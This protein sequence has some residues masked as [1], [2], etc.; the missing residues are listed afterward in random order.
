MALQAFIDDS[1]TSEEFVLGGH[2]AGVEAWGEFSRRWEELLP[3]Y[4][5]KAKNG[6]YHFKMTEMAVSQ[7]RLAR[8]PFFY[9]IIEDCVIC[10][11]SCRMN[12]DDFK[13]AHERAKLIMKMAGATVDLSEWKNPYFIVFRALVQGFYSNRMGFSYRLP[14]DE[15]V[16]FYFDRQNESARIHAT[17]DD[18]MK[19]LDPMA[20]ELFGV[21]PRFEDDQTL[22]PLQGA[23]LWAWWVRHWYEEDAHP[24]PDKLKNLDFGKWRGNPRPIIV[25][26]VSEDQIVDFLAGAA[27]E[28]VAITLFPPGDG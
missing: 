2:I 20:R 9:R 15:K 23:D 25:L 6:K 13:R 8:V 21:E 27:M 26:T 3:I 24:H 22:L 10:S 16:D 28:S 1:Y 11:I 12:M 18:Y 19:G 14:L 7:D 4:G 17:W 5:T